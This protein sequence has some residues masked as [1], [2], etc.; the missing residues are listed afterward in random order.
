MSSRE[1]LRAQSKWGNYLNLRPYLKN[2]E[3]MMTEEQR[4]LEEQLDGF[5]PRWR[6]WG[7]YVAERAWGTVREDYSWNGEAWS[8]FPFEMANSKVYRWGEDGIAGWCDRYQILVFAPAFWNG[9]DPI[10]KERL[11]GVNSMEGNHGEDVKEYYF[12]LDGIP[13]HSYM[14]YL[15]KYPQREFP[16]RKLIE[17]NQKRTTQDVEYEL[18]D[19]G[20]LSEN[21]YFDI[22]IE[23]AKASPEDIC[24]KI[25]AFNRGPEEAPLH[26]LPHLWFRNTWA[27]GDNRLPEPLI[28]KEKTEKR[29]CLIAD[30]SQL[31]SPDSLMFDYHLGNR[32]LYGPPEGMA[33]FT[34]NENK[35]PAKSYYKDGFHKYIINQENS[36]NPN[37][38]GTK[39]CIHYF[40]PKIPPQKSVTLYLRLSDKKMSDPLVDVEKIIFE[41]KKE[42][43]EFYAHLHPKGAT[44][45][46]KL[47]QRQAIAGMLWNKQV[48]LFD[49]SLWLDGDNTYYPPPP[50][51]LN[52][53]NQHW[54]HLN[55]M[56]V[57]LMPD[58]WEYPWFASWDLAFH[59]LTLGL[60]DIEFAKEQLWLLLFDQFQHPNGQIPAFEWDFSDLNPPIQA[61]AAWQL[62]CMQKE[63]FGKEDRAFLKK[64]LTKLLMNF[65][66]WVNRVDS[67]GFNVFEGG[68][69]GL[70]NIAIINR[71]EKL[72]GGVRVQQSDG[73]GWMGMYCLN[74]M[75]I[76][77]ELGK[78]DSTYEPIA[79][80]FFQHFVVIA[81]AMKKRD[82]R[83]YELWSEKDGFF[84]DV[85]SY[86]DHTFKQ[87]SIRSLVG[88]IPL[89]AVEV[90]TQEEIDLF[91]T[92]KRDFEWFLHRRE[93]FTEACVDVVSVDGQKKYVL[94]LLKGNHLE[95]VLKYIW[96][97][98]EFRSEYGLRSLS[99]FHQKNPFV[100]G[101]WQISYEPGEA[102]IRIKG[103]NSNWRGPIWMPTTYLLIKSLQTYSVVFKDK[104][105]Q[106]GE[107][108]VT[109]QQMTESFA[110]R[111]ISL[112]TPNQKGS[113][114]FWG[115]FPYAQD[116]YWKDYLLF[117]EYFH[118]DTGR[119]LG[120][121]HQT[122]WTGLVA[123]LIDE[124]VR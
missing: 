7:P 122:G 121:S 3:N 80:K 29:V 13:T 31:P 77:L 32:Y 57:M 107:D 118:G 33:I 38:M 97:P 35:I 68:F 9:C 56:R 70:D 19:T 110:R 101:D 74:L 12:Y 14:K 55:S 87:F 44:E 17:E 40:F 51:R 43:D 75:R 96:D 37:E 28:I 60:V 81:Y 95:R 6:K 27:W 79:T 83:N 65:A 72:P 58:K 114:P 91:P 52:I 67:A 24:I 10:L 2:R 93:K 59:C 54:Q 15:Y 23:Y 53:R 69:L 64:C 61:F 89:Y 25:E 5:V 22:F 21:R 82:D 123:N 92:F 78:E 116:P 45:E 90:L 100:F 84:Y 99:K 86:P 30:D 73:T 124:M 62:Y 34:D 63:R 20:I 42:A 94:S 50:S 120:A 66:W 36:I 115:D 104:F 111:L 49:V 102:L 1:K 71:S 18:V 8:Y 85:L 112:F 76:A 113:R 41:R 105:I 16:Y 103:G 108:S 106:S 117:H 47:I 48:Y 39:A 46:E 98:N 11:F 26:I 109:L 4:R 88:I 119:G